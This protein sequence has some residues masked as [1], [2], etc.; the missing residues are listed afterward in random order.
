MS[1]GCVTGAYFA[2]KV[3]P[4]VRST[5][6]ITATVRNIRRTEADAT[7][8]SKNCSTWARIWIGRVLIPGP[9]RKSDTETSLSEVM[10]ARMK[11]AITPALTFGST[12]VKKVF[13]GAL[14][15]LIAASSRSEEHTSE[16]Q[17]RQYLVCRLLLEKKN[18]S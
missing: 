13:S 1:K 9:V 4:R 10:K 17:S 14:P 8:G 5:T 12:M 15:R 3:R 7:V 18:T 6:A 11:A 2:R 16:L